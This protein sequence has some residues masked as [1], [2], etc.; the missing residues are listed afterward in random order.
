MALEEAQT[1]FQS[2]AAAFTRKDMD[3]IAGMWRYP[4]YITDQRGGAAFKDL[5]AFRKN[6]DRLSGFYDAQGVA[7]AK[8]NVRE[9]N[10]DDE[11]VARIVVDYELTD[12]DEKTIIAWSTFYVLRKTDSGE[13]K[14]CFAIADGEMNAWADRGTPLGG[15]H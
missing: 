2:Y 9:A 10:S 14:A 1:F 13:W 3:A 7:G 12:A 8:A 5:S 11:G 6:L 15:K 4:C